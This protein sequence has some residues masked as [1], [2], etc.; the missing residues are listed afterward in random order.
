MIIITDLGATLWKKIVRG[1]SQ[2]Q[3][4]LRL[5][6]HE[7]GGGPPIRKHQVSMVAGMAGSAAMNFNDVAVWTI[8]DLSFPGSLRTCC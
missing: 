8:S 4:N 6:R 7:Y 2:N 3:Q 1:L 5:V